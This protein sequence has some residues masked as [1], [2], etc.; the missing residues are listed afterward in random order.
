M[1]ISV[2]SDATNGTSYPEM[3]RTNAYREREW[4]YKK[5]QILPGVAESQAVPYRLP[6]VDDVKPPLDKPN[7]SLPQP[8]QTKSFAQGYPKNTGTGNDGTGQ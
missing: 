1:G 8:A 4:D 5:S 7:T 2:H 3:S 6:N